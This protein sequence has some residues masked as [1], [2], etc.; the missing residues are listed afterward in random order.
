[1]Y[2]T[3][4]VILN[5]HFDGRVIVPDEPTGLAPGT[6]LRVTVEPLE[7]AA[8]PAGGKLDLPLLTGV[9]PQ[10]VRA[11]MEDPEFDV[12]SAKIERFLGSVVPEKPQ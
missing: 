12:G 3:G 10:V 6:R 1:M 7:Q 4:M 2:N 11:I 8:A 9:D 5:A